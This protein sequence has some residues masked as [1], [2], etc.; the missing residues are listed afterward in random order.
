MTWQKLHMRS[1]I[2][3]KLKE[4]KRRELGQGS[5]I[6][7]F[8]SSK[9]KKI[10]LPSHCWDA[11]QVSCCNTL[12]AP[13]LGSIPMS[14]ASRASS[15]NQSGGSRNTLGRA[16]GLGMGRFRQTQNSIHISHESDSKYATS[17]LTCLSQGFV[18]STLSLYAQGLTQY[19]QPL[20]QIIL[21]FHRH[22]SQG[23]HQPAISHANSSKLIKSRQAYSWNWMMNWTMRSSGNETWSLI[24][25]HLI[26]FPYL[27][28]DIQ[29]KC[30]PPTSKQILSGFS[31]YS[32]EKVAKTW[33]TE[34]VQTAGNTGNTR[35][36]RTLG[37]QDWECF[38]YDLTSDILDPLSRP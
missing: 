36:Q 15:P 21:C 26:K 23:T 3:D 28:S 6:G 37:Y 11:W 25:L 13:E 31:S 16:E 2:K 9:S 20:A 27:T 10:G 5:W 34:I 12:S 19:P 30:V 8:V 18:F 38:F 29:K 1:I 24:N 22:D 33:G 35:H 17:E 14:R 4:K 7:Q 32:L